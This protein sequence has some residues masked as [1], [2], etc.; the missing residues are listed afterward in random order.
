MK[1]PAFASHIRSVVLCALVTFGLAACA[2][3]QGVGS[4]AAAASSSGSLV[5]PNVGVIDR[6]VP[7]TQ[8]T[9]PATTTT[10]STPATAV[11]SVP[12]PVPVT[13]API[14]TGS[15]TLDWTPPTTNSDGSALT[16]L[17]GYTVYYGTS[18]DSLTQSVKVSNPGLTAYT[19]SNLTSGTWYFA[20]TSYSST[21]VESTRS[22]V[23]STRI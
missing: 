22:G 11:A 21:G 8:G 17:A 15:A 18:P 20:V 1:K 23:I 12:K 16:N 14:S 19:L 13:P 4:P 7:V 9:T 3:D 2:S 5:A 6:T 10:T